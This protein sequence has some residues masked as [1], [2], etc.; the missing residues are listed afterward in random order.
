MH[1][2]ACK[3]SR[4]GSGTKCAHH[5]WL[6][7]LSCLQLL[8]HCKDSHV[9]LCFRATVEP[10]CSGKQSGVK[11]LA[12]QKFVSDCLMLSQCYPQRVLRLPYRR[13]GSFMLCTCCALLAWDL[14]DQLSCG[15]VTMVSHIHAF[16]RVRPLL[17]REFAQSTA[18]AVS[19]YEVNSQESSTLDCW[20][21]STVQSD[22][23]HNSGPKNQSKQGP[24][25]AGV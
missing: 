6:V 21:F 3:L 20:C 23:V 2:F 25:R 7:S 22:G 24:Y 16:V 9:K 5:W 4:S 1:L 14:I 13:Y 8:Q 11:C 19:V 10:M 18:E 17:P 15:C 12:V